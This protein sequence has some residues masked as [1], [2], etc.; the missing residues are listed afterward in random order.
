MDQQQ[1]LL[2]QYNPLTPT[3]RQTTRALQETPTTRQTTR[4]LQEIQQSEQQ[5]TGILVLDDMTTLA[6]GDNALEE[7]ATDTRMRWNTVN[8]EPNLLATP[9]TAPPSPDEMVIQARGRRQ[10]PLTFSPDISRRGAPGLRQQQRGGG[11]KPTARSPTRG[12]PSSSR[13]PLP[14]APP[15]T[16][17]SP[18]KR[19]TTTF[20][21]G[22]TAPP[23]P[24]PDLKLKISP[25]TK[26]PKLDT[27]LR[28]EDE[29]GTAVK[30][31]SHAQLVDLFN[32][33]MIEHPEVKEKMRDMVP[34]PDLSDLEETLAYNTKNIYKAM[35]SARIESKTDST[36]AYNRVSTYLLAFKK[37]VRE[38]PKRLVAGR[39]WLALVDYSVMAWGYVQA[40]PVWGNHAHNNVR[41]ACFKN[42]AGNCMLAIKKGGFSREQCGE[43]RK[44]LVNIQADSEEMRACVKYL[45]TGVSNS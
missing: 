20:L 29:P 34:A 41:S 30:G 14:A 43:I 7:L 18:R 31:L 8:L 25:L 17:T 16:R 39:Q 38:G 19:L 6:G 33:V 42:L 3:T 9:G 24:S 36:V 37:A 23:T 26:K 4:A 21:S 45:D 22:D 40:T 13:L 1:H 15:T 2:R 12:P 10:V 35:P 44:K 32:K 5:L 28:K 27:K 11:A